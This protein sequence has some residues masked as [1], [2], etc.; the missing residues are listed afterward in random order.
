MNT[1]TV[2]D[3]SLVPL[4]DPSIGGGAIVKISVSNIVPLWKDTL[5]IKTADAGVM[6]NITH[7]LSATITDLGGS[8]VMVT[9]LVA[10]SSVTITVS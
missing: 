7:N 6:Y 4:T 9:K 2:N 10:G 8:A 1:I 3:T 5:A